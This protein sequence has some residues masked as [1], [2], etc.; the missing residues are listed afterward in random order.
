M[1]GLP[2]PKSLQFNVP[3]TPVAVIVDVPQLFTTANVGAAGIVNGLAV[4]LLLLGLVQPDKNCV[5]V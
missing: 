2:V 3:T 5:T 4:T 1:R